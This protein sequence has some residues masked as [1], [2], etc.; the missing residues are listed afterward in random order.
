MTYTVTPPRR[1][2]PPSSPNS[3]HVAPDPSQGVTAATGGA[4][5]W[6]YIQYIDHLW[7][8]TYLTYHAGR[9]VVPQS[10]S[11]KNRRSFLRIFLFKDGA[12]VSLAGCTHPHHHLILLSLVYKIF[13][14]NKTKLDISHFS[15]PIHPSYNTYATLRYATIPS[16]PQKR[17]TPSN[18]LKP[19]PSKNRQ[20]TQ[21]ERG[22]RNPKGKNQEVI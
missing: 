12:L 8:I 18:H 5:A 15:F 2:S 17:A 3:A 22:R 11:Q 10:Q 7:T 13:T 16:P 20:Y 6:I 21:K 14:S 1:L 19:P 4:G 9:G